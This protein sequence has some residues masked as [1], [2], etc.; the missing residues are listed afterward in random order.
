MVHGNKF[1]F[2]SEM[3]LAPA[4]FAHSY[5]PRLECPEG[6]VRIRPFR[7]EDAPALHIAACESLEELCAWM[8]WCRPDY[9]LEHAGSFIAAAATA[10]N[11]CREFSFAIINAADGALLG[12]VGISQINRVHN[13]A[14]LGY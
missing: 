7:P 12:S 8:T 6:A 1:K 13:F 9:N 3:A 2:D 4:S 14:N 11:A 10:W 5:S